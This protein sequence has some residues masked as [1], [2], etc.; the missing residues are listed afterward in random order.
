MQ[1]QASSHSRIHVLYHYQVGFVHG[2]AGP[3]QLAYFH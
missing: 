1:P 3:S 2:H